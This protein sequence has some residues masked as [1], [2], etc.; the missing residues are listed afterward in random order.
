ME[1]AVYSKTKEEVFN[2]FK[3]SSKGLSAK[4]AALRLEQY[5]LNKLSEKQ[6]ISAFEIYLSQFKSLL[7]SILIVAAFFTYLIYF[8]GGKEQTNFIEGT[9]ILAIVFLI[10]VL[11]FTQ[12]YRAER[13]IE[14]LKKLLAFRVNVIRDGTEQEIDTINLVPGDLVVLEEGTK[15]TA[16]IRLIESFSLHVNESSLTGESIPVAKIVD[17]VALSPQIADQAN[18]VFSSTIITKGRGKG[19]VV[20][21]GDDTEIGKI[22]R[23]VAE[24]RKEE[25]PIQKRLDNLGKVL[26]YG[27]IVISIFVFLFIVF[28]STEYSHLTFF[29]R[30]LDSFIAAVA[31]AVA[32]IPEGLPAVVTI[33]LASGTQRM[34]KRK[35]L[36]RK[37]ASIET[38]GSIDTICADKTGTLTTGEMAVRKIYFDGKI[39]DL[40]EENHNH[41]GNFL[42]NKEPVPPES[43]DLILRAGAFCNNATEDLDK[44]I[45]GD[46]TETALLVSALKG[47]I[48]SVGTRLFEVPFSS[49]RKMMSVVVEEKGKKIVYTKGAPEVILEKCSK[50][51]HEGNVAPLNSAEKTKILSENETLTTSAF[52]VLGFAYKEIDQIDEANLENDLIFLGFQAMMDPPREDV[53]TLL[54]NCQESGIRIIMIT[55]DNLNTAKAVAKEIGIVGGAISGNEFADMKEAEFSKK[56]NE[57]NIYARVNPADKFKIVESLKNHGHIVAMTGDGVNDAP[58]LKKADIGVAMGVTGTDVAKEASDMV[59]LDEQ[60]STIV[61]A[62]EEGRGIFDNIRKFVDYLLSCNIGEVFVVFIGLLL[63]KD[64]PLTAVMLLWIN[65]ITDG[66]PAIALGLDPAEKGIMRFSPKKFQGEIINKRVWAEIV[67]F[68]VILTVACLGLFY[69]NLQE[70]SL[71]EARAAVFMGI[72]IFELIR[73]VNIRSTY[74]IPWFSNIWLPI[75]ILFSIVLQIAI[76]YVPSFASWFAV[77]PIDLFDW[78]YIIIIGSLVFFALKLTDRLL[79][80]IPEFSTS[81]LLGDKI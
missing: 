49:E 69:L 44:K 27:I 52:R 30:I 19:I 78:L 41:Q 75:A 76:V 46:P 71:S 3:T 23:F 13:A 61:A 24:T 7:I 26:G 37:L 5:G 62:I 20:K 66:L 57:I 54:N 58:A 38:L 17:A 18:M 74:N 2:L 25:T 42:I 6:K 68:G 11:G 43:L 79:D 21:T 10:T 53:K 65:V 59:M 67:I 73:L 8:L 81:K 28:I 72:I 80:K 51:I 39:F 70:G 77:S 9:L 50:F 15:V 33:S 4:E 63:F 31:L 12:E 56:V 48:K 29:E 14:A 40:K 36:V 35:S 1:T 60:F 45:I 34:L 47:G 22:A 16:D 32:A 55:G 64:L